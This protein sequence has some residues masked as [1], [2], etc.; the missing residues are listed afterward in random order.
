M[1]DHGERLSVLET[2]SRHHRETLGDVVDQLK[3]LN[4]QVVSI[5][6]KLDKNAG[7]LA[8]VAFVFTLLGAFVGMG[9]AALL[10]KLMG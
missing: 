8:G 7:F 3:T 6:S 10:K 5:N 2:D 9:G 4:E 1:K